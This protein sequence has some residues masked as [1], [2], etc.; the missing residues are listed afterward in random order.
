MEFKDILAVSAMPG[1]YESLNARPDGV[2]IRPLAGGNPR[3]ASNRIHTFSP[4]DKIGIYIYDPATSLTTDSEGLEEVMRKMLVAET[5]E[6]VTV[7]NPKKASSAELKSYL[8]GI[9][10]NYD[11]ERVYVSD[12]KKLIKWFNIIKPLDVI[13][14][15]PKKEVEEDAATTTESDTP[16]VVEATTE[17]KD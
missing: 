11:E 1:L 9:L 16:T 10:P 8:K 14:L 6:G 15:E 7:P 2:M 17:N 3:F 5:K 12:I 4:L 13:D